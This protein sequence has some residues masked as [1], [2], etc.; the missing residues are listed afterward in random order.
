MFCTEWGIKEVLNFQF[1]DEDEEEEE[2]SMEEETT[3]KDDVGLEFL[4]QK[5]NDSKSQVKGR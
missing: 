1:I 3:E 5:D 4:T 2:E